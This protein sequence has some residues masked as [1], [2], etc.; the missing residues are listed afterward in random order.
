MKQCSSAYRMRLAALCVA[1]SVLA[2]VVLATF[3]QAAINDPW[4]VRFYQNGTTDR[5]ITSAV[6]GGDLYVGGTFTSIFNVPATS[7]ARWNGSTWSALG[8]GIITGGGGPGF[9][10]AIAASGTDIYV[11][12]SFDTAGGV[13]ANNVA[14]WNGTSWSALGTGT[15]ASV[16][17]LAVIGTDLYAGGLFSTAGGVAANTIAKWNGSTWSALGSGMSN[18]SAVRALAV[19]GTDLYAGGFFTTA[20]GTTVNNVARWDGSTWSALGGGVNATVVTLAVIGSD[21][22]VGGGF[23]NAG[24]SGAN[25]LSRWNGS[26]W[27]PLGTSPNGG[28]QGL[29]ASGTDLYAIGNFTTIGGTS[30][31]NVARWN[32]SAWSALGNGLLLNTAEQMSITASGADVYPVGNFLGAGTVGAADVAHWDGSTWSIPNTTPGAGIAGVANLYKSVRSLASAS[33]GDVYAGG[34]FDG[35]GDQLA[36]GIAR[37]NGVS[38]APLGGGLTGVHTFLSGVTHGW[39]QSLAFVGTDLIAGGDFTAAGGVPANNIA[40]WNGTT[41]SALGTGTPNGIINALAVIGSDVYAGGDFVTAGVVRVNRVAKWNGAAWLGVGTGMNATVHALTVIGSDLY[42]GGD[43][44]TADGAPANRIAKW[45]GASWS[46]LGTGINGTVNALASI[47]SD[48]YAAGNFSNAGGTAVPSIAR[49]NGTSWSAVGASGTSAPIVDLVSV[50]NHLYA[51]GFFTVIGGTAAKGIAKWNG[52]SWSPLGSGIDG[53]DNFQTSPAGFALAIS[54]SDVYVGG[55]LFGSVGGG[56]LSS[57]IALW[58]NCGNSTVDPNEQCDDGNTTSGDCCSGTCQ[59]EAGGSSCPDDGEPCT[60][61]VCDGAGGCGVPNTAPCDD[62]VFCNGADACSGGSCGQH[63]GNPCPGHDVGP[64]CSDSCTEAGGGSCTGNDASGTGCNDGLFCTATDTC[65]GAGTCTG[66]GNPCPGHDVGPACNDSCTEAGGGSCSAPD[67]D[68]TGCTDGLFCNGEDMCSGGACSGDAGDPCAGG[69][70]CADACNE[71]ADN[72][73]EPVTTNCTSDS[74][75]CTDDHCSGG[76]AC[77]HPNNAAPCDDNL[78][79]TG[80]ETCSGGSCAAHSGDP[81]PGADG[82][83]DCAESCDEAGEACT[84]PDLNGSACTDGD[85]CTSGE[86]CTAG[87]CG[88]G[89]LDP[90]GCIDHYLC[91]KAKVT[92]GT[93]KFVSIPGVG[94]ADQFGAATVEVRKPKAICPPADKNGEGVLDEDTHAL[95]YQVKVA[96]A[97]VP[98][99]DIEVIDQFGTLHVDTV[100]LESLFVPTTKGLGSPPVPPAAGVADHYTCY[101]VKVTPGTPKFPKGVQVSV[102]DQFHIETRVYDVGKPRRLCVPVDKNGEGIVNE[103]AH[104]MCYKVKPASGE[105]KHV[106]VLGQIHTENQ[107]GALRLDT[108]K[109]EVLCVP[110]EKNP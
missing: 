44:T 63:A 51:T 10:N 110:A 7:I 26:A 100:K 64:S 72:C 106:R 20:G 17:A 38:W 29:G 91:Y 78:F 49:W 65:D 60:T 37:W 87:S 61:D 73:F 33:N 71:T 18:P 8:T 97:H 77:I 82:D 85:P 76:G 24:G 53:V 25:F 66:A 30:A 15:N 70:E 67:T 108:V 104:L 23:T 92:S 34:I 39:A 103:A 96:P 19:I 42:A 101:K 12:G 47:G 32:G 102:V 99:Q 21:L 57:L 105:P 95:S 9:V 89:T 41:W 88:G 69:P 86:T 16:S 56:K 48:L 68:G 62:L 2:V 6:I 109:E 93:P 84:L 107:F 4:D 5:L 22:Y 50:G 31:N 52:A 1:A 45:D 55:F 94:V 54:G 58:R 11:G 46:A 36:S 27:A 83:G 3:S 43:F 90:D 81:C 80:A 35:A 98:Q 59:L 74:N 79:C 75:L 28:V 13:S 40:R 14:R